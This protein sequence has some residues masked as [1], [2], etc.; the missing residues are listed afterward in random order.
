MIRRYDMWLLSSLLLFTTHI[1]ADSNSIKVVVGNSIITK[2]EFEGVVRSVAALDAN[3]QANEGALREQLLDLMV[4]MRLQLNMAESMSISLTDA[5]K[6]DVAQSSKKAI[7]QLRAKG[8]SGNAYLRFMTD[9]YLAQKVMQMALRERIALDQTSVDA[10]RRS[11]MNEAQQYYV[12]DIHFDFD[13]DSLSSQQEGLIASMKK[14]WTKRKLTKKSLPKGL[15]LHVFPWA[16]IDDMPDMFKATI[17]KMERS[18]VSEPVKAENGWHMLKLV[19]KRKK[20][21]IKIDDDSIRQSL[22][23]EQVPEQHAKWLAELKEQQFIDIKS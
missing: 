2:S 19:G 4:N 13:G 10:R 7:K 8:F 1:W 23:M 11:L 14:K 9:Q 5:E 15:N 6:R 17:A 18:E 20:S 12:K 16:T 3:A 21:G 22:F